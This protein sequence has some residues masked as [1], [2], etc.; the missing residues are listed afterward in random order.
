MNSKITE[1]LDRLLTE[2][3]AA[4]VLG[5]SKNTLRAW[6]VTGRPKGHPPPSFIKCGRS[7]RYRLS[8]L[9]EWVNALPS[10]T[11]TSDPGAAA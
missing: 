7:V 6:R 4:E 1:P 5:F 3:E 11:S 2:T 9:V 10:L 8:C